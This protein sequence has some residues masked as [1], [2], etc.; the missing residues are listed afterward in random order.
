MSGEAG[1]RR[2]RIK[3]CGIRTEQAA[4]AAIE[5][6]ADAIGFVRD[7]ASPRFIKL[8]LARAIAA[9][10]P[11]FVHAVPVFRNQSEGEVVSWPGRYVQIHGDE[12]EE[13]LSAVAPLGMRRVIIRGF[14]FSPAAVARWA[15]C[16]QVAALLIDGSCGGKGQAFDHEALAAMLPSIGK[17]VVLAGGLTPANVGA[18]V[19]ALRPYGVDVSS[20]V[21]SRPGV[22]EPAMIQEFCEAV[23]RADQEL[24]E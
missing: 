13:F 5:A 1:P 6:G 19:R 15:A 17:P 11:P 20:G 10:L 7:S 9:A 21:E 4:M 2:T 23:R 24:E 3:I 8:E 14:E 16:P 18:A 12:D 22:K